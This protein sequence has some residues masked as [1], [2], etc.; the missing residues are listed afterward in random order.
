MDELI[1]LI[2]SDGSATDVSDRIKQLLYAKAADRVDNARPE[3][4]AVMFGE[5]DSTGDNE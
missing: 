2:A 1:D 3:V 4:A 5:D